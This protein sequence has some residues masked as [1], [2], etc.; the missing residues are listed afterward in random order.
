[1][2]RA[3][4]REAGPQRLDKY[5]MLFLLLERRRLCPATGLDASTAPLHA[6]MSSRLTAA[7][8]PDCVESATHTW[9]SLREPDSGLAQTADRN[10][11]QLH[12]MYPKNIS[13]QEARHAG[14]SGENLGII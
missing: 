14:M 12:V 2:P 4:G 10:V 7:P 3:T 8:H 13:L 9:K 1:M 5:L 11:R 6:V